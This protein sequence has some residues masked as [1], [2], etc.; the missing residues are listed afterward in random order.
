VTSPGLVVVSAVYVIAE[1]A[2]QVILADAAAADRGAAV[3]R[4]R[5][6]R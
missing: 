6:G 4:R 2:S 1:K 3:D 5:R